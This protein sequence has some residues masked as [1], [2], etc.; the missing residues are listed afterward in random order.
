MKLPC[1]RFLHL[2]V[3]TAA[4]LDMPQLALSQAYPSRP[5]TMVVPVAAGGPTD[6]IARTIADRMR[7]SLGQAVIVE[8]VSGGGNGTIGVGR[9]A[10]AAPDGYTLSVGQWGTY[11]VNGAIYSLPYDLL[12]DFEPIALIADNPQIVV[13]KNAVPVK[14]LRELVGWLRANP[15]K[16]TLATVGPGSSPHMAG[17]MLQKLTDTRFQFV[18][19]RGA[20]PGMQDLLAGQS[21]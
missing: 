12:K 18:P 19:Y 1:G 8:N 21:T 9:V 7:V 11:V 6:T 20:A 5:I 3:A 14:D 2:A 4:L 10:R 17:L 16:A 15:D 13:S